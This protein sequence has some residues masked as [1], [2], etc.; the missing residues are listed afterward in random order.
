M[1]S[2]EK[3][4]EIKRK[5][6]S[7]KILKKRFHKIYTAEKEC[8]KNTYEVSSSVQRKIE[9]ENLDHAKT[10][11]DEVVLINEVA[12]TSATQK[13]P[14]FI[15][16]KTNCVDSNDTGITLHRSF[17]ETRDMQYLP[18]DE[19]WCSFQVRNS[20]TAQKIKELR[21]ELK[22]AESKIESQERES[23]D[24][25]NHEEEMLMIANKAMDE[26]ELAGNLQNK[27]T[28][29][30]AE[31]NDTRGN[32][33]RNDETIV[34]QNGTI[35]KLRSENEKTNQIISSNRVEIE[36]L[37][38]SLQDW[39]SEL[40]DTLARASER[41]ME[42][43]RAKKLEFAIKTL[44]NQLGPEKQKTSTM[45]SSA[46]DG[47]DVEKKEDEVS[48]V[49][50]K[51]GML[52]PERKSN[53]NDNNT[54][55]KAQSASPMKVR[56]SFS[57]HSPLSTPTHRWN[58]S[59]A[60][61]AK[62]GHSLT[63]S[64]RSQKN[65]NKNSD[66]PLHSPSKTRIESR[67]NLAERKRKIKDM[68]RRFLEKDVEVARLASILDAKADYKGVLNKIVSEYYG[69]PAE[70]VQ[71]MFKDIAVPSSKRRVTSPHMMRKPHG[72]P[73]KR[74]LTSP[75]GFPKSPSSPSFSWNARSRNKS[76]Y[77]T[78]IEELKKLQSSP[79]AVEDEDCEWRY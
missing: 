1:S 48:E 19:D 57:D 51:D 24:L 77:K 22:L 47:G 64:P 33:K 12:N 18:N 29:L 60:S 52:T 78:Q 63:T 31:I 10:P 41:L 70:T 73:S 6:S 42:S 38:K 68:K 46:G 27:V 66:F 50:K 62:E 14:D 39:N 65:T 13:I 45:A 15:K 20:K 4:L 49:I 7:W 37:R 74:R 71:S 53:V 35:D 26:I 2:V 23:L 25:K 59:K 54:P 34:E 3:P 28:V 32:I 67:D 56:K 61:R 40:F 9:S 58:S 17:S 55:K 44:S 30:E 36:K 21:T 5:T 69:M 16:D 79:V 72:S 75:R 11:C 8:K 76:R 43:E